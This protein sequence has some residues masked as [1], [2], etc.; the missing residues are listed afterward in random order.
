LGKKEISR[1][2]FLSKQNGKRLFLLALLVCSPPPFLP[3][4]F[5]SFYFI[6][7]FWI[8]KLAM[9]L[10]NDIASF[11]LVLGSSGWNIKPCLLSAAEASKL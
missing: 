8:E 5:L 7:C 10:R 4:F 11:F 3:F 1:N 6:S 9:K 2:C